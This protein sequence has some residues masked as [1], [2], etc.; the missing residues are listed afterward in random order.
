MNEKDFAELSAGAALHALSPEDET[1]FRR[2]LAEHPEWQDIVESDAATAAQ[3]AAPF[4]DEVPRP[5]IRAALLA[6]IATTPQN[7]PGPHAV[8]VDAASASEHAQPDPSS[9]TS[10][11]EIR[12]PRRWS[13][14]VFALAACLAL[15]VGVGV[16]AVALN[17]ALNRPA[18]VVALEQIQDADDAAEAS[19]T[20]DDGTTATAHW[21]ASLRSAVLVTDGLAAP[22][23][24][25][26]YEL[27]F[28]RGE[29]PISAGIFD[30]DGTTSTAVLDGEM[31]EGDVIAVTVE[32]AGGSPDG[33]PTTDPVIVIPTA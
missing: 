10:G 18:S 21:S 7:A 8:D 24:G 28:V 32:Q 31:H 19:V 26:T 25:R 1:L 9:T 29:T 27:W 4:T 3:L 15:L 22:A 13:R 5:D 11:G 16:G 12:P 2:A 6:Q 17:D 30:A 20:L 23:D 14:A 33:Q